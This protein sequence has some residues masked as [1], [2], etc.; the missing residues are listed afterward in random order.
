VALKRLLFMT[1]DVIAHLKAM[2]I[3]DGDGQQ[4][5]KRWVMT[6]IYFDPYKRLELDYATR[7]VQ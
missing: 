7:G 1:I 2:P 6:E 5:G 3:F 4:V